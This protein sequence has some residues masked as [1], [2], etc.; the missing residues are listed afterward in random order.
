[1]CFRPREWPQTCKKVV[2]RIKIKKRLEKRLTWANEKEER[3]LHPPGHA[4]P[5]FSCVKRGKRTLASLDVADGN[6]DLPG[7]FGPLLFGLPL[8]LYL[9]CS[10]SRA[11]YPI[12]LGLLL[13][14]SFVD[15]RDGTLPGRR[16]SAVGGGS[17][18]FTA[19]SSSGGLGTGVGR[20]WGGLEGCG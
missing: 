17:V 9:P 7:T 5:T 18:A 20:H 13:L 16:G 12:R 2:S 6:V 19:A 11:L 8:A 3:L 4:W 1:M 10:L 14:G 15:V